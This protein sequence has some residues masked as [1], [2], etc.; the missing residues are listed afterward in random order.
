MSGPH[1][2]RAP[3]AAL[4]AALVALPLAACV[5][6]P[7]ACP[8]IAAAPVVT[9]HI[10]PQRAATL[11]PGTLSGQACQD[12]LC[13]GGQLDVMDDSGPSAGPGWKRASILMR[14]LTESPIDLTLTGTD[15]SGEPIGTQQARFTPRV[16]HPWGP[17]CPSTLIAEVTFDVGSL[18]T[19][20]PSPAQRAT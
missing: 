18:R 10:T 9:I 7:V 19:A 2:L 12:G 16:E 20:T 1:A 8:A 14:S 3:F 4:A 17:Q 15:A 6:G 13:S 5:P 11:K